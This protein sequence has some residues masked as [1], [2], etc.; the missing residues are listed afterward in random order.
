M[1]RIFNSIWN[2]FVY[3]GHLLSLG[4]VSIVFTSAILLGIKITWD[5]MV[6]VYLGAYAPYIYNRYREFNK[7][8]LTNPERTKH[9]RGQI[10][11]APA[12]IAFSLSA[13]IGIFLYFDK[14]SALFFAIF[15]VLF[16]FSYS[17]LFKDLS[18]KIVGF[19]NI[20][21]ALG[22]ALLAILLVIYYSFPLNLPLLFIAFFIYLRAFVTTIFFDIK[23]IESD[24]KEELL[25]LPVVLGEEKSLRILS[26][27]NLLTA[28][29]IVIGY[30]LRFLPTY[31]LMLLLLV[32][33][34]FYYLKKVSQE[35]KNN[36]FLYYVFADGEYILWPIFILIGKILLC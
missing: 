4:A 2:E 5:F 33:Y 9:L 6:I 14:I 36:R 26:L 21:I 12:I 30:I 32:P 10:K 19:K 3:G 28:F 11:F 29:P 13:M 34:A 17:I 7:D 18:K 8:F 15:L 20:Y 23:D 24:K 22:W 27:I 25:T 16:S 1:K 31:S 35:K